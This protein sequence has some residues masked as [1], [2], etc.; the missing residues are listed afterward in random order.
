MEAEIGEFVAASSLVFAIT[1]GGEHISW[2]G[3]RQ[4]E[5]SFSY[6]MNLLQ[7]GVVDWSFCFGFWELLQKRVKCEQKENGQL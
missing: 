1:G 2:Q 4:M 6:G 5:I 7:M 3:A